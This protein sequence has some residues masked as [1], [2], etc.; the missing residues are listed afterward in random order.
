MQ[1]IN[2]CAGCLAAHLGANISPAHNIY[3]LTRRIRTGSFVIYYG[4]GVITMFICCSPKISCRITDKS[5]NIIQ[6]MQDAVT[7]TELSSPENRP[8]ERIKLSSG[9]TVTVYMAAVLIEGY[10]TAYADGKCLSS[11]IPFSIV[12]YISMYVPPCAELKFTVKKIDCNVIPS[13]TK[14]KAT[15]DQIKILVDIDTLVISEAGENIIVPELNSSNCII[16]KVCIHANRVLD[17]AA[18][19]GEACICCELKPLKAETCQYNAL[20][21]GIKRIY[22]D[23][24]EL[25]KYGDKGILSPDDVSYY[26]LFVNGVLQPKTN[27]AV[28]RG[29][30]KFLTED[31][32]KKDQIITIQ[33]ILLRNDCNEL[34]HITNYLYSTVSDGI[35]RKFTN[36]DELAAYGRRGIPAP[37]DASYYNLFINGVLQ[38]ETNYVVREGTLELTTTDIPPE[39]EM[40]ILESLLVKSRE[41]RLFWAEPYQYNAYSNGEKV[42]TDQDNIEMYGNQGIPFPECGSYQNLFVNGVIQPDVNYCVQKGLLALKTEDTPLAGAP[43]SLQLV[44][45]YS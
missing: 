29:C 35:K 21:D 19:H 12:K 41:D 27:Y 15:P 2:N 3:K 4:T 11:P 5:G 30:L 22:T 8:E 17:V 14:G 24:D 7:Y 34:V 9:K 18:F 38:P 44:S 20:S 31:I 6:Y 39:G 36:C 42:Y 28:S 45:M 23:A 10:I 32:P 1:N 33:F 25:K 40:I 13:F 16:N 43:I 37:K 26:N